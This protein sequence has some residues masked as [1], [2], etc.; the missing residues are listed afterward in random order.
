M[1]S[2]ISTSLY[3]FALL[4]C[5]ALSGCGALTVRDYVKMTGPVA[6][7]PAD[8]IT[9]A[10]EARSVLMLLKEQ[11]HFPDENF[12]DVFIR[13]KSL[14]LVAAATP[15]PGVDTSVLQAR[16]DAIAR[17]IPGLNAGLAVTRSASTDDHGVIWFEK[18]SAIEISEMKLFLRQ[19]Q[20]YVAD[21]KGFICFLRMSSGSQ[22]YFR[23]ANEGDIKRLAAAFSYFSG[24]PVHSPNIYPKAGARISLR[25]GVLVAEEIHGPF[26]MAGIP[27]GSKV[28]AIDGQGPAD[29]GLLSK[30][31][32]ELPMGTHQI[33][34]QDPQTLT[35]TTKEITLPY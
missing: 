4:G 6:F 3:S 34:F 35:A 24:A 19:E 32:S 9:Q 22:R 26:D 12:S 33:G 13:E 18:I 29:P 23:S 17:A 31:L 7:E 30:R 27:V 8:A 16:E 25:D 1:S 20:A 11:N 2:R 28:L 10:T 14:E 15:G 5:L 21:M